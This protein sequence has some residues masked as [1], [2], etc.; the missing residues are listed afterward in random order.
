MEKEKKMAKGE[1]KDK[2]G[3]SDPLREGVHVVERREDE[4]GGRGG[5]GTGKKYREAGEVIGL[6][7]T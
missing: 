2:G 1:A 5:E 4:R 6:V 7:K 3:D